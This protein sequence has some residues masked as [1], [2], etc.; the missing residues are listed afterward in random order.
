MEDEMSYYSPLMTSEDIITIFQNIEQLHD[1]HH[2]LFTD[3]EDLR[4]CGAGNGE[5]INKLGST[6]MNYM[7]YFKAYT[8]YVN[9]YEKGVELL[10]VLRNKNP[11]LEEWITF[12]EKVLCE[13][14]GENLNLESLMITPVQRIP[15]Y[16]LLLKEIIA[17]GQKSNAAKSLLTPSYTRGKEGAGGLELE[18]AYKKLLDVAKLINDSFRLNEARQRVVDLDQRFKGLDK[19]KDS[20]QYVSVN[21][22][23]KA[24]IVHQSRYFVMDGYV[25]KKSKNRM[26]LNPWHDRLL[27]LCND[28]LIYCGKPSNEDKGNIE[29]RNVLPLHLVEIKEVAT[30]KKKEEGWFNFQIS[31]ENDELLFRTDESDKRELWMEKI[32]DF[33]RRTKEIQER[34]MNM[35]G[36]RQNSCAEFDSTFISSLGK[37]SLGSKAISEQLSE[38]H[39]NDNSEISPPHLNDENSIDDDNSKK[40]NSMSTGDLQINIQ[41][42]GAKEAP[43]KEKQKL[44]EEKKAKEVPNKE[45]QKL[46][47]KES[48]KKSKPKKAKNIPGSP[49][50]RRSKNATPKNTSLSP[51]SGRSTAKSKGSNVRGKSPSAGRNLA[52]EKSRS[53]SGKKA[54][55]TKNNIKKSS[56]DKNNNIRSPKSS[57]K[58]KK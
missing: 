39:E 49:K 46:V 36:S 34:R 19:F 22:K 37:T 8:K 43:N 30:E 21:K 1:M 11:K 32:N 12:N 17:Q 31:S 33:R 24:S 20:I 9:N 51:R 54:T 44:V 52:S 2:K 55:K 38:I 41:G 18:E 23:G 35:D 14:R 27:I 28:L 45:K 48:K 3:F 6:F 25:Q 15:R 58:K 56:S 40:T 16:L 57:K 4:N 50:A 7:P 5:L 29:V 10:R 47:D 53:T 26:A 42:E 13:N